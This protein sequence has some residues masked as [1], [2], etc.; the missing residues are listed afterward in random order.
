MASKSCQKGEGKQREGGLPTLGTSGQAAGALCHATIPSS[1]YIPAVVDHRGGMPCHGTFLL[2]QVCPPEVLPWL[3]LLPGA[4]LTII[5][6]WPG[7][8]QGIQRRITVTLV[9]ETGSLI[10]WK[11]VRE[12]VVGKQ[13]QAGWALSN[14]Q[15]PE[16]PSILWDCFS[17]T[18]SC[19]ALCL[20]SP[21]AVRAMAQAGCCSH[22]EGLST[23][24]LLLG[25]WAAVGCR[26]VACPC[27]TQDHLLSPEQCPSAVLA[28]RIRNTP[29]ADE[30]LIDPNILSLNILS[31]GYISPSQ[32]DRCVLFLLFPHCG[33]SWEG[34]WG[35]FL[36]PGG[37]QPCHRVLP[38]CCC[39][40][41]GFFWR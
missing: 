33:E 37:S 15:P 25:G 39:L 2:H 34:M 16:F 23:S 22:R 19:G 35:T 4:V 21:P 29:E 40:E 32:D 6:L 11:E 8:S 20:L 3:R 18:F 12:L 5:S 24:Y 17:L 26:Q 13:S 30:S 38:T 10:H 36:S 9:H 14:P 1:S 27:P 28:G 41:E 7:G 31:S